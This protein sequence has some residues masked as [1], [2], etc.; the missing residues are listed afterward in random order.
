MC[1]QN[2]KSMHSRRQRVFYFYLGTSLMIYVAMFFPKDAETIQW[3]IM[4]V[5][6]LKAF[7]IGFV[8]VYL[9]YWI[10]LRYARKAA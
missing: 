6:V 7:A 1:C 4:A 3:S 5:D 9:P 2:I 8:V 10:W